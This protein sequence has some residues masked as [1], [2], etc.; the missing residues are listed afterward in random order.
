MECEMI[1]IDTKCVHEN[2]HTRSVSLSTKQ[3]QHFFDVDK[4]NIIMSLVH[5]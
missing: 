2:P 4:F 3:K 5:D 1:F